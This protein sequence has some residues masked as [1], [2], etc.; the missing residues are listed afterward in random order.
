M[1][2]GPPLLRTR[3]Q[4]V[5]MCARP[6]VE[7]F[8]LPRAMWPFEQISSRDLQLHE[9]ARFTPWSW[10]FH[11]T[12]VTRLFFWDTPA[13]RNFVR[14]PSYSNR[15]NRY[16]IPVSSSLLQASHRFCGL[17]RT[18]DLCRSPCVGLQAYRRN[19]WMRFRDLTS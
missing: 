15:D 3:L 18:L 1:A 14:N 5:D 11:H 9:R 2:K 6:V 7:R 8:S 13:G 17:R 12:L 19:C 16:R 10:S 4:T